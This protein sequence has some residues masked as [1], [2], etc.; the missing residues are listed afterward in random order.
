MPAVN[1][2]FHDPLFK[3]QVLCTDIEQDHNK[4]V[5]MQKLARKGEQEGL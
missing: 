5:L 2:G 4:T 1:L 3:H